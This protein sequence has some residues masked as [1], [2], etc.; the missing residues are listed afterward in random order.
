[1]LPTALEARVLALA[2]QQGLLRALPGEGERLEDLVSRG[3]LEPG[4]RDRLIW[5]AIQEEAG[6][7]GGGSYPA[8]WTVGA[9]PEEAPMPDALAMDRFGPY[10]SLELLGVGGQGRVYRAYDPRLQ[11]QVAL[12]LLRGARPEAHLRE[13]RSQAQVEH[14]NV[15]RVYEVGE[16]EGQPYI[17]LQLIRGRILTQD[18]AEPRD[19]VRLIRDAAE[20]VHAAHRQGLLHLDLKP[21][22]LLISEEGGEAIVYVTDFGLAAESRET[23]KG[24]LGSPPY[25]APE[26][27]DR[28]RAPLDQRTDVYGLGATLYTALTGR[29]PFLAESLADLLLQIQERDPVRPSLVSR[30]VPRDLEAILLKAMAKAPEERY[31]TALAFA[32]DLERWLKGMP[33]LAR[34][35]SWAGRVAKRVRRNPGASLSLAVLLLVSL[36]G[37]GWAAHDAA[38]RRHTKMLLQTFSEDM[39]TLELRLYAM[40][41]LPPED[42]RSIEKDLRERLKRIEASL[43]DMGDLAPAGHYALGLGYRSLREWEPSARHFKA[44]WEAGFR[45]P[46]SAEATGIAYGILT[47]VLSRQA[48]ALPEPAREK[49]QADIQRQ[50]GDPGARILATYAGTPQE[51]PYCA[52]MEAYHR[53]DFDGVFEHC[54]EAVRRQPW[55]VSDWRFMLSCAME[56]PAAAARHGL[57]PDADGYS[58]LVRRLTLTA[59]G[60][61]VSQEVL[62]EYW[63]RSA[64]AAPT[65]AARHQRLLRAFAALENARA[66]GPDEAYPFQKTMD[67]CEDALAS[68][69]GHAAEWR[70]RR[71][72]ALALASREPA[73]A[74]AVAEARGDGLQGAGPR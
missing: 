72:E 11:R 55:Q 3:E 35:S 37:A 65:A 13:A 73:L 74:Q 70:E 34:P 42:H 52:A 5:E 2:F 33:I 27:A 23:G 39:R 22:N 68:D 19:M 57:A 47:T 38:Q 32:D 28:A 26:Q 4:A 61:E 29:P 21:S 71:D 9:W 41:M 51:T 63:S 8:S 24:P 67:L 58:T 49:A 64:E 62:G 14:R 10:E 53:K 7:S 43:G 40:R 12:K 50:W 66:I 46:E 25:C 1:M 44:A 6:S 56:D 31:A 17:A 36:A 60:D 54:L 48:E 59:P 20:G 30:A 16:V 18:A 15:C 69:R 45:T